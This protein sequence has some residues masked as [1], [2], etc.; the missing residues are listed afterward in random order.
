ME[1]ATDGSYEKLGDR[2]KAFCPFRSWVGSEVFLWKSLLIV[3][4]LPVRDGF[5]PPLS[6]AKEVPREKKAGLGPGSKQPLTV[7]ACHVT[8]CNSRHLPKNSRA[9]Q[10]FGC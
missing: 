9:E 4:F 2:A 1:L 10:T 5:C 6:S 8:P 3:H 7:S